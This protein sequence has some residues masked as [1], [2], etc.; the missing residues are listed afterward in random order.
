M[1]RGGEEHRNL[2]ISQ[3][4]FRKV[5]N[6][7]N[8]NEKIEVVEYREFSSKNRPGSR[9]Q[10]NIQNKVTTHYVRADLGERCFVHLLKFYL[11]KLSKVAHEKD[12][13]FGK[14]TWKFLPCLEGLAWYKVCSSIGT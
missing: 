2:K 5:D 6:P 9:H 10:L 7:S 4:I 12:I 8:P 13:F 14:N 1:L 3:L 11:K